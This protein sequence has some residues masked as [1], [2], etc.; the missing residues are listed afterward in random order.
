MT[1]Y[2]CTGGCGGVSEYEGVCEA[3]FCSKENQP[4]TK[5][6][7]PDGSHQMDEN[8]EDHDDMDLGE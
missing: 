4:L 6:D 2:I 5:C 1:H 8:H 3:Q 7:C